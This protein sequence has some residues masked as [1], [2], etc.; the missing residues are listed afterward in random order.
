MNCKY[1]VFLLAVAVPVAAFG[2]GTTSYQCSHGDLQRRVEILTEPGVTVPCEV[3]YHKDTEAPG[4]RQVLWS[5]TSE[6]GY[7]ERKTEEFIAKLQGWGWD[8][9]AAEAPA[10]AVEHGPVADS[11]PAAEPEMDDTEAL[12]P[13]EETEVDAAE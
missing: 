10:A 5:A 7:C 1:A 8:C 2:Q 3:H 9:G 4:E 13:M 6:E 12:A 11:E